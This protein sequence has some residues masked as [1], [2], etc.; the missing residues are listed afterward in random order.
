M[1]AFA[2]KQPVE[3]GIHRMM[4]PQ[5]T[6]QIIKLYLSLLLREL[7]CFESLMLMVLPRSATEKLR[8][9]SGEMILLKYLL[10]KH[11]DLSSDP[12]TR[13]VIHNRTRGK[14]AETGRALQPID[15]ARITEVQI[16]RETFKTKEDSRH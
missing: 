14:R 15:E 12:L 16:Q 2:D 3:L 7:L 1:D 4:S 8:V 13:V 11:R 9:D 10:Q 5:N 6:T